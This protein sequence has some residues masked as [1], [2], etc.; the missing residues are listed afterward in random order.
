M[1]SRRLAFAGAGSLAI[2][3]ST[4]LLTGYTLSCHSLRHLAGGKLDCFSCAASGGP[5]YR[6]W[7]IV[8]KL[9]EHHMAWAWWSLGAVCFGDLYV[10]LCS[11][12][13]IHDPLLATFVHLFD[14]P[15]FNG[16]P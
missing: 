1:P 13:I 7:G 2:L 16:G 9:N 5:R 6:A 3:A 4:G 11:M 10:R 14:L 8:T 12:G 15:I